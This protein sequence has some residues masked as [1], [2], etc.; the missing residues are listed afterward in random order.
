MRFKG[1]Q[2]FLGERVA[3]NFCIERRGM[4]GASPATTIDGHERPLRGIVVAGLAPAM[5]A[6]HTIYEK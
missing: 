3:S 6:Q 5:F 1:G 4:A 2:W